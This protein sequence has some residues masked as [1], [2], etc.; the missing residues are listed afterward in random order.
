MA[1][2]PDLDGLVLHILRRRPLLPSDSRV[3]DL[4][5]SAYRPGP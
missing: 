1:G 3:A 5:E 2:Y 4:K